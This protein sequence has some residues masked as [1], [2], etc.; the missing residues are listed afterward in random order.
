M[1]VLLLF[2]DII[3][4]LHIFL[5]LKI[6]QKGHTRKVDLK[7]KPKFIVNI[8]PCPSDPKDT[9]LVKVKGQDLTEKS[10]GI[11]WDIQAMLKVYSKL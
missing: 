2:Y 6:V 11:M 10:Y 7:Q 3:L 5:F 9:S 8:C 4:T 1:F